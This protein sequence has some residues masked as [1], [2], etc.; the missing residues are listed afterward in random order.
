MKPTRCI[1]TAT[2]LLASTALGSCED[3]IGPPSG[4]V[5]SDEVG[6]IMMSFGANPLRFPRD[7]LTVDSAWITGDTQRQKEMM[8][9]QRKAA[10][11]AGLGVVPSVSVGW[12]PS[13]WGKGGD[14]WASADDYRAL[15]QWTKDTYMPCLPA[16]STGAKMVLLPN[17]N[18]FSE[19]HF[20]MPSN[21]A[22]FGYV[23]AIREVFFGG[24]PHH[25]Q[26]PTKA[27]KNRFNVLYPRDS[28]QE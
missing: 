16:D 9:A 11:S 24:G 3:P 27:Q 8:Q 5:G 4:F 20:I 6:E 13:P 15:L 22:G 23:D 21:L 19:G 18:E 17:W 7:P 2:I 12:E 10:M 14:G 26:V 28:V 25:D 1:L